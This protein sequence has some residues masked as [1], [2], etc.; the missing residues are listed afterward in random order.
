MN[1]KTTLQLLGLFTLASAL[2]FAESWSGRLV[3]AACYEQSQGKAA[4][5]A[6]GAKTTSFG[7]QTSDGK[8]FKLD[9]SGNTKAM[10]L[11]KTGKP[12]AEVTISGAMN[13]ETVKVDSI[14]AQQ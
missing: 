11:V 14:T 12:D 4:S 10:Q 13:G 9:A 5:C 8:V 2:A 7:I 3:D 6:P 1:L